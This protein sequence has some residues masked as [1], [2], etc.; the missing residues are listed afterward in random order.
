VMADLS[1]ADSVRSV[2]ALADT[3]SASAMKLFTDINEAEAWLARP[4]DQ[5]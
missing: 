1:V 3:G 2:A 5:I 4:L